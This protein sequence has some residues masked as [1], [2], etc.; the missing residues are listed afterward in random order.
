M[1]NLEDRANNP[2]LGM[3][4]LVVFT[5]AGIGIGFVGGAVGGAFL[6]EYFNDSVEVLKNSSKII[7]YSVD[8]TGAVLGGVTGFF[9]GGKIAELL[10]RYC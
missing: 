7:Q 4:R 8:V 6:G 5:L 9:I 10:E 1:R 3:K 2:M